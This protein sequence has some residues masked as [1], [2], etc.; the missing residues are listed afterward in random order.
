[1]LAGET[2]AS[3]SAPDWIYKLN[4]MARIAS[5]RAITPGVPKRPAAAGS[6][7][8]VRYAGHFSGS[9]AEPWALNENDSAARSLD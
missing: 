8:R 5:M 1:M 6:Q 3:S 4:T 7:G 9:S 2:Q